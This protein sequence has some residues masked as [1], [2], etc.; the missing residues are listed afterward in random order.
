MGP[1]R[2]GYAFAKLGLYVVHFHPNYGA[3][4][5]GPALSQGDRLEMGDGPTGEAIIAVVLDTNAGFGEAGQR[6][7][8]VMIE[9]TG[10][11]CFISL[12]PDEPTFGGN[13]SSCVVSRSPRP[14][15]HLLRTA[16]LER[17]EDPNLRAR[18]EG[19]VARVGEA[20]VEAMI[21]QCG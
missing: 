6:L 17:A 2:N 19:Q 21:R 13:T 4:A 9:G 1:L 11:E 10:Q 15:F 18:N 12:P 8:K 5:D 3:A 7:A 16:D 20:A 14:I